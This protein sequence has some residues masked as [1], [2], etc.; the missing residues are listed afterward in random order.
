MLTDL[1]PAGEPPALTVPALPGLADG[2]QVLPLAPL[3]EGL[4]F[5][6]GLNAADDDR[7][8]GAYVVQLLIDLDGPVDGDR[9]RAALAAVTAR[10]SGLR[11]AFQHAPDGTAVQVVADEVT[12]PWRAVDLSAAADGA[13]RAE[14]VADEER[15]RPFD[16]SAAPLLRA[17]LLKLDQRRFRLLLTAHH[18]VVDGWSLPV[19]VRDLLDA[20]PAGGVHPEPVRPYRDYL[21]WLAGRDRS[22]A[23]AAWRAA[24]AGLDEPTRLVR[25][26]PGAA[27]ERLIDA[28]LDEATTAALTG[29]ARSHG[30]TVNTVLQGAWAIL[31][32][33]LTGRDDVVFGTSV[34]GRPADLPGVE[35]MVG[36]FI[37]TVPVRVRI[38]RGEPIAAGLSRLQHDQAGLIAHHHLSLADI[39]REAGVGEL[40]DTL[41]V[42]EN[43]PLDPGEPPHA[44]DITVSGIDRRDATH[45]PLSLTV[46]PGHRL[47]LRVAYRPDL[48]DPVLAGRIIT[49][50]TRLLAAIAADAARPLAAVDLLTAEERSRLLAAGDGGRR[51][52]PAATLAE[53]F[54]A[55]AAGEP[56]RTAVVAGRSRL[57]FGE[58]NA[59]A[60]RLAHL[61]IRR[62]VGP[63]DVVGLALPRDE[64]LMIGLLAVLKAGAAALPLDA[65]H[66]AERIAYQLTDT[67]AAC[68]L[69]THATTGALPPDCA[70]VAVDDPRPLDGLPG[71][72][73]TDRDR[74]RPLRA[75]NP[76]YVIYTSGSTG[77]PK[78][79]VIPHH[80]LANLFAV[81]L[82]DFITPEVAAAGGRRLRAGLVASV[83]FDTFWEPVLWMVAGHELHLV[84]EQTRLDPE[85]LVRQVRDERIDLLDLTP[86]YVPQ[87]LAAG[88]LDPAQH[89]PRIV[90]LGGEAVGA[91]LWSFL[92]DAGGVAGHNFYG[93]T[94]FTVDALSCRIR[95][96]DA[97]MVGRPVGNSR[98]YVLDA[99]LSPV[100]PGVPGELYLAGP[101][102]ARGYLGRP[103]LT[104]A[105]FVADP[106][107]PPG[108]RM[109]R[110]GDLVRW[111]EDGVLEYLGRTDHQVKI[112][113]FRIEPGEIEAELTRERSIE[114]AV[115]V[116]HPDG[117]QKRLV[118]YVVP[119]AG[120]AIDPERL[121]RELSARLPGYLVPAALVPL[122][123]LPLTV[124]GKLDRRALPAPRFGPN[125]GGRAARNPREQL[126]CELFAEVLGVEGVGVDD[127]FFAL[128]GHSLLAT[129]L[130][131]R[132]R[133]VLDVEVTIRALFDAPTVAG[134]ADVLDHAGS[135]R[136][137]LHPVDRPERLGLSYAQQRLWFLHQLEGPSPTYNIP[138]ALRLSGP[139]DRDALRAAL[140]DVAARH[141]SLRT[142]IDQRDGQPVQRVL[143]VGAAT[144]PLLIRDDPGGLAVRLTEAARHPFDLATEPPLRAWLFPTGADGHVL[145]VLL[146]H[147]AG[148]EWSMAPLMRDLATAYAAR[149]RGEAPAWAPLRVQYADYTRWQDKL[150]G[151]ADDPDSLHA[152]QLRYWTDA[153]RGLPDQLDL[154]ADRPRPPAAS[155]RGGTVPFR[156]PGQLHDGIRRLARAAG[157]S[158]FMVLQAGLAALLTRLGAGTD[159]PIG[160]PV[161]GRTDDALDDLVGFFV[162]TVVLRTDTA[163][164]PTFEELLAR[165]RRTDLAAFD[166]QDVPF[167]HVVDAANPARSLA[168]HPLFQVMLVHYRQ[169]DAAPDLPGVV[170]EPQPVD[171]GVAKVDLTWYVV[172]RAGG[173]GIDGTLEYSLDLFDPATA[174]A[175]AQ[176]LVR[177][178]TS[179]V[180]DPARPLADLDVLLPGERTLLLAQRNDTA[181]PLPAATLPE[182][183]A[184]QVRATPHATAIRSGDTELS[185]A[186]LDAYAESLAARLRANGAGPE[187]I[188][189]VAVPR[190][191]DLPVALLAVLKSGAAYLPLDLDYPG[192]RI[193]YMLADAAPVCVLTTREAA[194]RLPDTAVPRLLLDRPPTDLAG[195]P[196]VP[197]APV[198]PAYVI[199]T[200]G[201]TGRPKGVVVSHAALVNFL[202]SMR[203]RFALR[204]ADRLLAVTTIG[205]DIAALE[206]YLPLLC[207]AAVVIA[208]KAAVRDPGAL[209]DLARRSGATIMQATPT[210]WQAL[211]AEPDH[212]PSGLR[213]LVGGEALPAPLAATM[214]RRAANVT[215][216][217][218][219][220]ESTIWSTAADV[221]DSGGAPPIGAPIRNTQ[222]FVLDAALRPV[223][224]GVAGEL[225]IAGAGLARGY[226][227]R[228]GLTAERFVANPFGAPGERMYRTGD[229]VRWRR[230]G[231][232]EFLGRVD[233]QVKLRGFRIELGEIESVLGAHPSVAEARMVVREDRPGHKQLV[234][235]LVP[236][237]CGAPDSRQL[238]EHLAAR[239]PEY[240]LPAAFV[241]LKALPLTPNGKLD[242]D[243]LPVPEFTSAAAPR[244]PR[245]PAERILTAAVA[246]VLGVPTVGIEDSFFELGGDSIASIQ[247]VSRARQA[248][249][250][251]TVRQVFEHRT[252]EDL[253]RHAGQV[254]APVPAV[255]R[256]LVTL[257]DDE[258]AEFENDLGS[259]A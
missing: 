173:D 257:T 207:G 212:L 133:R 31:L 112:R 184:R 30:L 186:D 53:A 231:Q 119:H 15:T 122:D 174:D 229:L 67:A 143:P 156:I 259:L 92:L 232:L 153:L 54:E 170:A 76:A 200:S 95:D 213:M 104:A 208:D 138:V 41:L 227:G 247:L 19:L 236:R 7:G 245:T 124:S 175:L 57:G 55:Q 139:L 37:N 218:G 113:G 137:A 79:V 210:L 44:A 192:D 130:I 223:P 73:P 105:R 68:V 14:L 65:D 132:I 251:L 40:F 237:H 177:L 33:L 214:H 13:A 147:I 28:H 131:S 145:L 74:I 4:L 180:V 164:D 228:P 203:D 172:E 185:Y 194:D 239:L 20:Y 45:Y 167:E 136:P 178:L 43:Y 176:R 38:D 230:D 253:A 51:A 187:R 108:T 140:A 134:L 151:R 252:V 34:S 101:Q 238:R 246:E 26:A 181:A 49:W 188:V 77:A 183:I 160:T 224:P 93:P 126:L 75:A 2:A 128:G 196:A 142:V 256:P 91:P 60:N 87:L 96:H 211:L 120:A 234:A 248:G 86:S 165:V 100:P 193:V 17:T 70:T 25:A 52:V 117:D 29:V 155:Y 82:A 199:Y 206:L 241:T 254:A 50:L 166:H 161:A 66:P 243:A 149:R 36:L 59:R 219:P 115:V 107:G 195:I 158:V 244:P 56:E 198:N 42:F 216:L 197:A 150:L 154:P 69:A 255:E 24:L 58:L 61:L 3:Q 121:R 157:V 88:L 48:I 226:L 102:L 22:A 182:L 110:T 98:T 217:Y 99:A 235:Y 191:A 10:H 220:T 135:Q 221:T 78:G 222:V 171:V 114:A 250:A 62:G 116:V 258:L 123:A 106:Y 63:E 103:G 16:L 190:T 163:G 249:L 148:D 9:L 179:A 64:H 90:M 225:Y 209:L 8:D 23:R 5:L 144:P 6:A 97:P 81:H 32:G 27:P 168:R 72:D 84:D 1:D 83:V 141:E 162:N 35:S 169:Q 205:F 47:A 11:A 12:V 125:G 39:Q 129:R 18:L 152:R 127:D 242:R 94:E 215:N 240:M 204:G 109:Y 201:S 89:R 118:G 21:A 71:H 202:L 80:G 85:A 189:A 111:D 233:H 146:H 46:T 159:I